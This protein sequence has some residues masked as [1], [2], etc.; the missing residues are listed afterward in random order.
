M[1][2][3]SAVREFKRD[4]IATAIREHGGISAAARALDMNRPY[5][6]KLCTRLGVPRPQCRNGRRG[7]WGNEIRQ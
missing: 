2:Y 7:N 3:S 1:T 5:L 4:L 6:Q